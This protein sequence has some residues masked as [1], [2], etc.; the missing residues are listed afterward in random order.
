MATITTLADLQKS[1]TSYRKELLIMPVTS[2][3][4]TLQHMRAI[5]GLKGNYVLGQLS[6]TAELAPY[7]NTRQ[8][9][10][11]FK[12]TPRTLEI[13]LGN[14]AKNFDPNEA[15]GTIYGSLVHNGEAL[16]AADI[17]RDI[18]FLVAGQLGKKLNM[19][20]FSAVRN[21]AGD[22]TQDLFN[23]FDTI[24]ASEITAKNIAAD[25]GNYIEV[26][27]VTK[28]N[29]VDVFKA[30]YAAADD[31]LKGQ[32]TKIYCT[33]DQYNAYLED[34]K[35]TTGAAPYNTEFKKTVLEGSDG[36]AEFCPLSS[37]K[38]SEFIH[39]S[40]QNN[41]VYGYGAGENPGETLEV[42]KYAPWMLTLSAAMAFGVQF[43]SV[44]PE[45]LL[46]AK[47]TASA[48]L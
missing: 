8:E 42:S 46:V 5:P 25:K 3:R 18:L 43:E 28:E 6:G 7:K 16:K 17:N 39:L 2:A 10:G 1:A 34:Y 44:S 33:Y 48:T 15:W 14:C 35:A 11:D 19:A 12:I 47:P 37:K 20:I 40:P 27:A 30:I 24:T 41:M 29:A 13:F 36:L 22:T 32:H 26:P 45:M 23:G 9:D 38:G 31:E 21:E 4:A